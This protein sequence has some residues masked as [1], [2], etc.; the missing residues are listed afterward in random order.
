MTTA[1]KTEY[2]THELVG[3]GGRRVYLDGNQK[4][5]ADNGTF[6]EPSANAFSLPQVSSCPW[7]TPTCQRTCYVHNLE[8]HQ[9]WLHDLYR[10][11]FETIKAVLAATPIHASVWASTLAQWIRENAGGGFRWHV[12]GDLFSEAYANWVWDV[13]F[14]AGTPQWI[15]TRSFDLLG[16][17]LGDPMENLTVNLSADRD[18]YWLARQVSDQWGGLRV[19]Y[20]I[21]SLDQRELDNVMSLKETDVIFPDYH[22]RGVGLRP[23]AYRDGS[24][25]WQQLDGARRRLVCPVDA[26]GKSE[27]RRCGPC[28]KCLD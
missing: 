24:E 12:S 16:C 3:P 2:V 5:T 25:F 14:R 11:N 4:I 26:Y 10:H 27:Q 17:L 13:A 18:N 7:S 8:T 1:A 22:L 23:H 15:Y 28:R 6:E 20:L 21:E 9:G 19:C